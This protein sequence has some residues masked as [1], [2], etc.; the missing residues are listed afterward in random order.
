MLLY[1]INP[2]HKMVPD[3]TIKGPMP[4]GRMPAVLKWNISKPKC[5]SAITYVPKASVN[6][7]DAIVAGGCRK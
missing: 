4:P 5:H 1:T 3:A 2:I 7:G 6:K